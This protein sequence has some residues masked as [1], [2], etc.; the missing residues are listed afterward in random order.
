M[1]LAQSVT[2]MGLDEKMTPSGRTSSLS[3]GGMVPSYHHTISSIHLFVGVV[4]TDLIPPYLHYHTPLNNHLSPL[5]AAE[6]L[7]CPKNYNNYHTAPSLA[8]TA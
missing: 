7:Q 1:A 8:F 5:F 4:S 6:P 3:Y 2:H